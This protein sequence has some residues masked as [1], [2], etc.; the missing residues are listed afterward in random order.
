MN[1][2]AFE[3]DHDWTDLLSIDDAYI[4]SKSNRSSP[5]NKPADY[6]LVMSNM[7]DI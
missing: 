6:L 3:S 2:E 1:H 5:V 4:S 7:L